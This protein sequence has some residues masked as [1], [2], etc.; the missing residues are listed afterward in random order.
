MLDPPAAAES[1]KNPAM[2]AIKNVTESI[3]KT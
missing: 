3:T 1:T 2:E